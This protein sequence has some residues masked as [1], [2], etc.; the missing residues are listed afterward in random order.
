ML[1]GIEPHYIQCWIFYY[2]FTYPTT[3]APHSWSLLKDLHM[4]YDLSCLD[5]LDPNFAACVEL[6]LKWG[7]R[8][9]LAT[10]SYNREIFPPVDRNSH[11]AYYQILDRARG[12]CCY[13]KLGVH[14]E[15]VAF[16]R[17]DALLMSRICLYD[18]TFNID[19][20][21]FLCRYMPWGYILL[22]F[23]RCYR[24]TVP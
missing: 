5:F 11:R 8:I 20:L 13:P 6:V 3:S 1:R 15:P 4:L 10:G 16:K 14:T 9:Y 2:H 19:G 24:L 7:I 22:L 18:C 21:Y 12:L 23:G 17:K